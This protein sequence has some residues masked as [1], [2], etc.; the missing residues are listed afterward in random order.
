MI[1]L[2]IRGGDDTVCEREA[3]V[4]DQWVYFHYPALIGELL[5]QGRNVWVARETTS[6]REECASELAAM[7]DFWMCR[8]RHG[9]HAALSVRVECSPSK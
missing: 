9:R 5:A 3:L 4:G 8:D 2:P 1:P 6:L 7:L